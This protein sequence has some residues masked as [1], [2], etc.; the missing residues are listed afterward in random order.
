MGL[1]KIIKKVNKAKSAINSVKGIGA[2]LK[3]LQ[4]DSVTDQLGVSAEQ[5]RAYLQNSRKDAKVVN[6]ND[7]AKLAM[8]KQ[9]FEISEDLIYPLNDTL[10]NYLVFTILPRRNNSK[11]TATTIGGT[12]DNNSEGT[13]PNVFGDG[14]SRD[15]LLYVP[16]GTTSDS[17]VSFGD[18]DFSLSKRMMNDVVEGYKKAGFGKALEAGGAGFNQLIKSQM[19]AFM[20]GLTGGVQNVREGRAK[21]P[22]AEAMFEGISFRTHKFDYEFWPKSELEAQM[23]QRIIYSFRTAMLPDTYGERFFSKS[24]EGT[25]KGSTHQDLDENYFNFPNVINI[26]YEGP[27]EQR[28]DGFLPTVLTDM[29]VDNFNGNKVA[30]IGDGYPVSTSISLSF[31][32]IKILTQESYQQISPLGNKS[33]KPMKS[34]TPDADT[35]T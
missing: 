11:R 12:Q 30:M 32:E 25:G 2:K 6:Q 14:V 26:S 20:N 27:L 3:S 17:N 15:I 28:L 24:K 22:M 16:D 35:K 8:A 5:A 19:T 13:F 7:K 10:P 29:S 34:E 33:I 4:Y 31:Q 23:V 21:N 18:A 9:P 1:S